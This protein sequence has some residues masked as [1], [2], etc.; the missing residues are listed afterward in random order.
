MKYVVLSF[1]DG[2]RDFYKNA[3]S[4]L[5][6]HSLKATLNVIT[7]FIGEEKIDKGFSSGNGEFVSLDQVKEL[8]NYG[9]EI[10]NHS[11]IHNNDIH[12]ILLAN[13][14]LKQNLGLEEI[15]F[16]SPGSHICNTNF[17]EYA[18]LLKKDIAYI[19]SGNQ[20]KRDGYWYALLYILMNY[21]H[22]KFLFW[23]YHKRNIVNVNESNHKYYSSISCDKETTVSQLEN[24][25]T[26][27]PDN[28]A[29]I[30]MFHSILSPSDNGY[31]KDRWFCTEQMFEQVCSFL[32]HHENIHVMTNMELH[33]V[34]KEGI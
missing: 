31:Q 12:Q 22:S 9:I 29:A 10:A 1:D 25:I 26:K 13:Q 32:D 24:L 34:I 20:V 14:W 5:K 4:I 23:L 2:R 3:F 28:S 11:A 27:I 7:D 21:T 8:K 17:E 33:N 19:R 6:N 30:L 18:D 15:G 16:A